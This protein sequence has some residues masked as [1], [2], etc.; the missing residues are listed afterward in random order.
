VAIVGSATD[1]AR[2]DDGGHEHLA[3]PALL[4][5]SSEEF[6]DAMVPYVRDGLALDDLV[7][8][9]A[10]S[11]NIEALTDALG[12]DAERARLVDTEQWHPHT[13][14]R[15]RAFHE[16]ARKELGAGGRGIRLAGEPVW[17]G[18]PEV[19]LE[20]QRYESVLNAVLAPF[21]ATLLC[22]YDTST[23]PDAILDSARR[24]HPV[25]CEHGSTRDSI[26]FRAP[27]EALRLWMHELPAPPPTASIMLGTLDVPTGRRFVREK[28][29]RAG[30]TDD[31]AADLAVATSEI[32]S[33]AFIHGASRTCSRGTVLRRTRS[34]DADCGS[35]ASSSSFCRSRRASAGRASGSTCPSAEARWHRLDA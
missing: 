20:W 13:G 3:H 34:T 18:P 10:R 1:V 16:I 7:F 9:A 21:P 33:N 6:L 24:N 19:V 30:A 11:D 22:L 12:S 17:S 23:L 32:L 28:A 4:Y 26:E 27:E 15:L 25:L 29:L 2:P 5:G 8:V 31:E 14:P 35:S